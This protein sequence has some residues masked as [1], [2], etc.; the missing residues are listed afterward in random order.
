MVERR[1]GWGVSRG[2]GW[3]RVGRREKREREKETEGQRKG[4]MSSGEEGGE[5]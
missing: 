2:D 3:A 1:G 4:G 5:K